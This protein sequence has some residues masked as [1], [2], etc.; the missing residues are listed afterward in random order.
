[1]PSKPATERATSIAACGGQT[2]MM[3]AARPAIPDRRHQLASED[4]RRI[5]GLLE[6]GGHCFDERLPRV[7]R[8]DLRVTEHRIGERPRIRCARALDE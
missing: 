7:D 2:E 3:T 4:D 5:G 6:G 1:M 8:D